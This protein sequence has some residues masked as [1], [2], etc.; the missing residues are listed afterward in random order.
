MGY[1]KNTIRDQKIDNTIEVLKNM[2]I[3]YSLEIIEKVTGYGLNDFGWG[4]NKYHDIRKLSYGN[5]VLIEEMKRGLTNET[6]DVIIVC[7]LK[8]NEESKILPLKV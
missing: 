6:D 5:T 1:K 3:P 7:T 2:D 8:K 4:K